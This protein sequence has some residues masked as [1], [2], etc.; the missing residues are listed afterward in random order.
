MIKGRFITDVDSNEIY[1]VSVPIGN[2]KNK[3]IVVS[4]P[5]EEHTVYNYS[6][7]VTQ[8]DLANILIKGRN[9]KWK[10]WFKGAI[11][12]LDTDVL[13][14]LDDQLAASRSDVK[15]LA[16]KERNR[17]LKEKTSVRKISKAKKLIDDATEAY[18]AAK[19][20]ADEFEGITGEGWEF[21]KGFPEYRARM[22][23][24][25]ELKRFASQ[26]RRE[27]L[28]AKN[29][30]KDLKVALFK[31]KMSPEYSGIIENLRESIELSEE[32]GVY[33]PQ[34]RRKAQMEN[35]MLKLLINPF[36]FGVS[37][38]SV[39]KKKA[40]EIRD[41]IVDMIRGMKYPS[42]TESTIEHRRERQHQETPPL[43]E[44]GEFA[45]SI[46]YDIV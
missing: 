33:S 13:R 12:T 25:R 16:T 17:V 31:T 5:D 42:N 22:S 38:I 1:R 41:A 39:L 19:A 3:T 46:E 35:E 21:V 9:A 29:A 11:T 34:Y 44:T 24:V 37:Y 45:E 14:E 26:K 6:D 30:L 10:R 23:R 2:G 36:A 7:P 15:R 20:R 28:S 4:L 40:R 18:R 32:Y 43:N 8:A 27:M